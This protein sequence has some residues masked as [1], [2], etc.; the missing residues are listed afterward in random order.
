MKTVYCFIK[1]QTALGGR[2]MRMKLYLMMASANRRR[3]FRPMRGALSGQVSVKILDISEIGAWEGLN[4][5]IFIKYAL[6]SKLL[7]H[8]SK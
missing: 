1:L 4:S 6:W 8:S 2:G 3:R 7:G 5:F